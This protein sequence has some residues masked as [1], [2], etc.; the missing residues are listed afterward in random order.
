MKELENN[1]NEEIFPKQ[2]KKKW[3]WTVKK[4][5]KRG[6]IRERK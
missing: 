2:K 6:A 1:E 4:K 3:Y 5:I